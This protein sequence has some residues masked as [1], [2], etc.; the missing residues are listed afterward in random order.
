MYMW[1]YVYYTSSIANEVEVTLKCG[2]LSFSS[3]IVTFT[4]TTLCVNIQLNGYHFN[5]TV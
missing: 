5:C 2:Q 1:G 3:S 4:V